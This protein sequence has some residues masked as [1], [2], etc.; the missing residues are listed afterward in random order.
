MPRTEHQSSTRSHGSEPEL[1][2]LSLRVQ[3]GGSDSEPELSLPGAAAGAKFYAKNR[4]TSTN[5]TEL[6][7]AIL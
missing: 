5:C 1:V 4:H 7:G 6:V 3:V 2:A